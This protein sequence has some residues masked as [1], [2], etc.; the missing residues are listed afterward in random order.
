MT[1]DANNPSDAGRRRW[2]CYVAVGLAFVIF[3]FLFLRVTPHFWTQLALSV[4]VLCGVAFIL[5]RVPMWAALRATGGYGV[6]KAVSLGLASA[7]VL[8]AVFLLGNIAAR[9]IFPF[10]DA[11]IAAVYGFGAATPRWAIALLL[12]LVIGPGEEFFW[13]G[14]IQRRLSAEFGWPGMAGSV[15]AYGGVHVVTCNFMLIMAALVC[16]TFWAI[17]YRRYGSLWINMISH[18][19]W[20]AAIFVLLPVA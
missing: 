12:I 5:E 11:E 20:A 18:A 17:L 15:L 3:G 14:Y 10:G 6:V 9:I 7:A 1:G 2:R 16:G 13:R 19:A 4:A 8:Y